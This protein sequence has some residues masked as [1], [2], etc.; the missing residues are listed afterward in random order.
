MTTVYFV[1]HAQSDIAV[2]DDRIRPLT[3]KGWID[4]NLVADFL[5]DKGIDIVLSS[6]YKRA[7]DTVDV[8]A[9]N[10][11]LEIE[12]VEDFREKKSA[13]MFKDIDFI[14]YIQSQ[15]SDFSY[16]LADGECLAEVQKRN[17]AALNEALVKYKDKNIVI[18]THGTALSTIINYYDNTYGLDDCLAMLNIMP[19]IVKMTFDE[20]GCAGMEKINLFNPILR[21]D[22]TRF[23]VYTNDLGTLKAYKYT[24]IFARYQDK[25]LYCRAKERDTFETAGGHIE[26]GETALNGA[27]R[28]LYDN[29]SGEFLITK[30][31]P[32][33]GYPNMWECTGGSA[34]AGDD[35]ITTAIREVNEETGLDVR[36]ENGK[37]VFTMIGENYISD[38]WLFNQDFNIHDVALQ[39]NET[40]DAKYVSIDEIRCMINKNEFI[41]FHYLEDLFGKAMELL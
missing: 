27:K 30:R 18:G 31:A 37:C 40:I 12:I 8:F 41:A 26:R 23:K 29:S 5:Y 34:V 19:W 11:G 4:R 20:N 14:H 13:G 21:S 6:P 36:Q 3:K 38:V 9:K 17:I 7:I 25:W 39:E 33:K 15:W 22:N 10:K 16:R 28:E 2:H 24:V 32:N 1:R 35:S